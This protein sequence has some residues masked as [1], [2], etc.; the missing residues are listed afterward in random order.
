M[1]KTSSKTPKL[2]DAEIQRRLAVVRGVE[3]AA[4]RLAGELPKGVELAEGGHPVDVLVGVRGDVIVGKASE[5]GEPYEVAE[6]STLHVL[7]LLA[8]AIPDADRPAAISAA[9]AG[10]RDDAREH[11]SAR[12]KAAVEQLDAE[13]LAAAK[14]RKCVKTVTPSGRRGAVT[15]KPDVAVDFRSSDAN[16]VRWL[17]AEEA[18]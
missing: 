13:I 11:K 7:A 8:A 18:A 14:R 17:V 9:V 1:A 4:K 3:I 16:S 2:S 15:G 5:P 6:V 10:A 12:C